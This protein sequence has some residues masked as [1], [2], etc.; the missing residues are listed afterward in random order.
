MSLVIP[1]KDLSDE[2]KEKIE[3]EL[4]IEI[5]Q[6]KSFTFN[7]S[8]KPPP[9]YIYPFTL[10]NNLV[11]LPLYYGIKNKLG[12]RPS[13]KN[14]PDANIVFEGSLRPYQE[15]VKNESLE[16]LNKSGTSII[17]M[18]TGGGK[19]ITA[20]FIAGLINLK[21]LIIIK[22]IVL[23]KQWKDSIL[24]FCP[25]AKVQTLTPKSTLDEKCDFFIMNALN[26]PKM[27]RSF[28][29]SIG[30]IIV[31]EIHL[32]VTKTLSKSFQYITPKYCLGL[33]ATPDRPDGMDVLIDLY[34]GKHRIFR[35][36]NRK[37]T[38]YWINSGFKPVY[39][40]GDWNAVLNQQ[41]TSELHNNIVFKIVEKYK[42]RTFLILCKRVNHAK[43]LKEELEERGEK[44]STLVGSQ[45][46]YD[47]D[48]RVLIGTVQKVGVGFDHPKLNA[49]II[50]GDVEE[51]FIQY[52]GRVMRTQ[53]GEPFIFDIV[54]DNASLK[55]HH[56]TRRKV[57]REHGGEIRKL[58][59]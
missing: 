30:M 5:T 22:N 25:T 38:A 47:E 29:S 26:I 14:Y 20:I 23:I 48:S 52:L 3:T 1:L 55:R 16:R 51:Y 15:E 27:W 44:V 19:T 35:K 17:S 7:K 40:Q 32:I 53:E 39:D 12:K 18:Y 6:K 54:D 28:F 46:T 56:Y 57:Y 10:V 24:K 13:R 8:F 50:A 49:L 43:Y 45:K 33:S 59:L 11:Y 58:I 41:A 37:H 9:E 21:T 31:D 42:D 36:L 2:Q 4:E 34:F